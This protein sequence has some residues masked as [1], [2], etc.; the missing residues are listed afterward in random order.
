MNSYVTNTEIRWNS[1]SFF[2]AI[3]TVAISDMKLPM[4]LTGF[5]SIGLKTFKK[6]ASKT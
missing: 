6:L 2:A 1:S 5:G 4:A 3:S